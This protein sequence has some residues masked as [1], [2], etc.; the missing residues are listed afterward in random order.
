M[1]QTDR[2]GLHSVLRR[3]G[4]NNSPLFVISVKFGSEFLADA[5]KVVLGAVLL[6]VLQCYSCYNIRKENNFKAILHT[7]RTFMLSHAIQG[8]M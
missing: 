2:G 7:I 3:H 6:C 4:S 1:S 5:E 8:S